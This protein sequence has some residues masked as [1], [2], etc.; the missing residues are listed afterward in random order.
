MDI[1]IVAGGPPELVPDFNE[2]RDHHRHAVWAGVDRGV[3][4][5]LKAGIT[6]AH[7]F[8]D[9]DSV[10]EEE[11]EWLNRSEAD[12]HVFQEQKDE[13]DL[14][15]ALNWA[16]STEGEGSVWIYGATGGRLD[17]LLANV[18]MLLIGVGSEKNMILADRQ[19]RVRLLSPGTYE[20]RSEMPY[21]SLIPFTSDVRG[22]TLTG[23]KYNAI[24]LDLKAG[25]SRGVSNEIHEA[26]GTL[27]FKEGLLLVLETGDR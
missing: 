7:A 25:T 10:T 13:T 27:V 2:L 16:L 17:H 5:L 14:E 3:H 1:V 24:D 20:I 22:I 18:Q 6:P 23:F 11:R 15:L 21:V 8:G 12:F 4:A 9:F 26:L 19:N